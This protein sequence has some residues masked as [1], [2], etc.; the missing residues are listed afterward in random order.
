MRYW[1]EVNF[2]D[3]DHPSWGPQSNSKVLIY[4]IFFFTTKVFFCHRINIAE[5]IFCAKHSRSSDF[6]RVSIAC[7]AD[8]ISAPLVMCATQRWNPCSEPLTDSMN[9]HKCISSFP[10]TWLGNMTMAFCKV[11]SWR[12]L[13]PEREG[14]GGGGGGG[15][16][17]GF[18]RCLTD[19][20][21]QKFSSVCGAVSRVERNKTNYCSQIRIFSA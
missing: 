16:G 6:P 8:V 4:K 13:K 17:Q 20:L 7:L 5:N 3:W 21:N 2:M 15:A 11:Q 14:G 12:I 1:P 19:G 10:S 9:Y 18:R